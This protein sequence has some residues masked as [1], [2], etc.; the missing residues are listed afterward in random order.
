MNSLFKLP[1]VLLSFISLFNH[2]TAQIA[3]SCPG[4]NGTVYT[5]TQGQAYN[6]FCQRYSNSA[7]ISTTYPV[8]NV[9]F[10]DCMIAC[11]NTVRCGMV[12]FTT[13]PSGSDYGN[14]GLKRALVNTAGSS[15][16]ATSQQVH[17]AQRVDLSEVG[18]VVT[19]TTTTPP[20]VSSTPV[21]QV[22]TI[23]Y[24]YYTQITQTY[25]TYYPVTAT[26]IT[27]RYNTITSSITVTATSITTLPGKEISFLQSSYPD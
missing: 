6:I 4:A 8:T 7:G 20:A 2:A 5:D 15:I 18:A 24:N 17:L 11:D 10:N 22:Q 26:S 3:P 12:Q 9:T 23:Y 16:Q 13:S 19:T 21:P 1:L 27:T 14:C 25:T